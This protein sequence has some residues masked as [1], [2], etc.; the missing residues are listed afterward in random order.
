MMNEKIKELGR[1]AGEYATNTSQKHTEWM[2]TF[3]QKFAELI[4]Q[5]CMK[6]SMRSAG[7]DA[8]YEAWYLIQQHFGVK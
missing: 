2:E 1:Q 4:I 5:E 6:V 8:E 3:E 7:L